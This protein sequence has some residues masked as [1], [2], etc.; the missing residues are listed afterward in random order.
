MGYVNPKVAGDDHAIL[1]DVGQI[2]GMKQAVYY[3]KIVLEVPTATF[4]LYTD[5]GRTIVAGSWEVTQDGV[6]N[7]NPGQ[8]LSGGI[9]S[10][11]HATL[12]T[13]EDITITWTF[14]DY[15]NLGQLLKG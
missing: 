2:R 12:A 10:T 1:A 6:R 15:E 5:S 9:I 4:T 14:Y 7:A 3:G 8:L 13:D 11:N